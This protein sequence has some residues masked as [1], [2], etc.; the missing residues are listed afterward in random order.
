MKHRSLIAWLRKVLAGWLRRLLSVVDDR[1]VLEAWTVTDP[2]HG[3]SVSGALVDQPEQVDLSGLTAIEATAITMET[4]IAEAET[5][6]PF[7][8]EE[9]EPAGDSE[10][11]ISIPTVF[12]PVPPE[13]KF[14]LI[15]PQQLN[16]DSGWFVYYDR[17]T[18]A[19]L[20][21][22]QTDYAGTVNYFGQRSSFAVGDY[23]TKGADGV[24]RPMAKDAFEAQYI[25]AAEFIRQHAA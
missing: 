25:A 11:P 19:S 24:R 23:L 14:V 7:P 4:V 20:H 10:E 17:Q 16:P 13:V 22:H 1:P 15:Q 3:P 8:D 18:G 21:A 6:E 5:E 12:E 2:A 9:S